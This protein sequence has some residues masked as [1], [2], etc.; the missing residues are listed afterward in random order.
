M[1]ACAESEI[2]MSANPKLANTVWSRTLR[3]A[4][5]N[6]ARSPTNFFILKNLHL[7]DI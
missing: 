6:T 4:Q 2:E 7:K 1:L 5:A 3:I